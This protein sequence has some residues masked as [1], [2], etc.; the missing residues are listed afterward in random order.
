MIGQPSPT[1]S[2]GL[3]LGRPTARRAVTTKVLVEEDFMS[4]KKSHEVEALEAELR[5]VG[6]ENRR[7]GE[8]LRSL[9][10]KYGELQGKV[11]GMMAAAAATQQ[12]QSSTTSEGGSAASPSRKR[13]RSDSLETPLSASAGLTRISSNTLRACVRGGRRRPWRGSRRAR[14]LLPARR[15]AAREATRGRRGRER[16]GCSPR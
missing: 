2:L 10:A 8:M 5:R 13:V 6:E 11:T 9:V 3:N 12:H 4:V 16:R 15:V 7:L 1:L 14:G